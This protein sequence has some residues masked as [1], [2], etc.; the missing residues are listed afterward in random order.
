ML[1]AVHESSLSDAVIY[2]CCHLLELSVTLPKASK[3][4]VRHIFTSW[5][6]YSNIHVYLNS[7][8][9]PVI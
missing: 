2:L 9:F 7:K 1:Q 8:L 5:I 3:T 6:M 4:S